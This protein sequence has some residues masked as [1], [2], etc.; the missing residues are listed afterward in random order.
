MNRR[1]LLRTVS[2]FG[3]AAIPLAACGLVT[4]TTTGGVTTVKIDTARIATNG[5][6]VIAAISAI[7]MAPSIVILLGPNLIAAQAA[8][9]AA[10]LA[11]SEFKALTGPSVTVALDTTKAQALVT[12]LVG[13]AQQ[14]LILVQGVTSKLTG[15][16]ATNVGNYVAATLTLLPLIQ[17]AAGMA[18]MGATKPIMSEAD[19]LRIATH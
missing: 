6:A 7:L 14:A 4:S 15:V 19:A 2:L 1:N 13:D 16:T 5:D 10:Q 8:L 9:T 18:L 3:V 11:L 17:L 12:S